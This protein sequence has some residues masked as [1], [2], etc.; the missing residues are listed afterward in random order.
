MGIFINLE[1]SKSVTR[2]EWEDVYNETLL[3]VEKFPL[4]E[5]TVADI[6]GVGTYCFTKT[7]EHVFPSIRGNRIGWSTNADLET[8]NDAEEYFLPKDLVEEK[9]IDENA[10]D[11]ILGACPAYLTSYIDDDRFDHTYHKWGCKTQGRPYHIY[12][13]AIACLI[14]ARLGT[15]AFTYGDITRGQCRKA[16][17]IANEYLEHKIDMPD[18]CYADRL[19]QRISKL[20]FSDKEKIAFFETFYLGTK[21]AA[22]GK[23]M[24]ETFS[25]ESLNDY[26]EKRFENQSV[27]TV[28]F[29]ALVSE[30]LLLGFEIDTLCKYVNFKGSDGNMQYEKFIKLIMDA[31]LHLREKN[32]KDPLKIDQEEEQPYGVWT[33]FAQ[34]VFAGA[35]NNKVDRYVPI[36]DLRAA[37]K[38]GM[39]GRIDVDS[40]IDEYLK[41]ESEQGKIDIRDNNDITRE[42]LEQA[43]KQDPAETLCQIIENKKKALS[44][45]YARYDINDMNDLWRYKSGQKI[46]PGLAEA[47]GKSRLFLEKMLSEP[48][49]A[50]LSSKSTIEKYK[51]LVLQNQRIWIRK[52]DWEQIYRN[53]E[54]EPESFGRYYSLMRVDVGGGELY[55]MVRALMINNELYDF[56]KE[57]AGK[58]KDK[59][60]K[61]DS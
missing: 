61:T 28:G 8:L 51:W 45:S 47:L 18:R 38:R 57:L 56:S 29:D 27:G 59:D 15:K 49:Y 33:L 32:C 10:G 25:K 4:A 14:E 17:D 43:V 54:N 46:C 13:L 55:K 5:W 60:G 9:E 35:E 37:L 11:A 42:E 53:L 40:I 36:E 23:A 6:H 1:I 31:K 58:L 7:E 19:M 26:W 20:D 34:L 52:E 41:D 21:D 39:D 44:E 22:V 24:R 12:L 3:L 50:E 16:V 2:K 30:Y 48:R